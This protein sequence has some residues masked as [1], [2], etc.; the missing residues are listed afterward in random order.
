MTRPEQTRV[1]RT[2]PGLESAEILRFGSVHRNTF[3]DAPRVLDDRMQLKARP[4]I[5][6]AGQISGV[7]GYVE[8][9]AGGFV[10]GLLLAQELTGRRPMPPPRT[11]TLGGVLTHLG[12]GADSY[13]PSNVTWA[14][15]PPLADARLKRADRHLA[16]AERALADLDL[17][18]RTEPSLPSG[19]RA[20]DPGSTLAHPAGT[21]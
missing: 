12:R 5:Y 2:I 7:E 10:C 19:R 13:Q 20:V 3:V 15:L 11:T 8:S 6:L 1:L 21:P 9:C 4:G 17:W 16:L 18:L 14:W